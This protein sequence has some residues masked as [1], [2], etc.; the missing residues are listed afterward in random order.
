MLRRPPAGARPLGFAPTS[1]A[2]RSLRGL[3]LLLVLGAFA[4]QP[5][6]GDSCTSASD[7]SVQGDR[8]CDTT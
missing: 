4:C 8:T 6:I 1:A 3:W 5:K 7:C 2:A